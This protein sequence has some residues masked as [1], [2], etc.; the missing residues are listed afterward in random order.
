MEAEMQLH[1]K[2]L[3]EP[4]LQRVKIQRTVVRKTRAIKPEELLKIVYC[5]RI[6]VLLL[7]LT[8]YKTIVESD[9]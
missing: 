3:D 9:F 2:Y 1:P 6:L 8:C 4:T 7:P 5:S